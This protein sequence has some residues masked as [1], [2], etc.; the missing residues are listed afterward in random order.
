MGI[1]ENIVQKLVCYET[2]DFLPTDYEI[3]RFFYV[4]DL[5]NIGLIRVREINI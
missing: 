1:I 3:S 5:E 2:R 4:E